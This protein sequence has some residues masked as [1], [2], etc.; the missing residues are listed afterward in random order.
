MRNVQFVETG[1]S[2][3]HSKQKQASKQNNILRKIWPWP[4]SSVGSV[5]PMS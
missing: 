5:V 2:K 1:I 4:R 3:W